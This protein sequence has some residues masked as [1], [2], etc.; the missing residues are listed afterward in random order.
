[1]SMSILNHTS[2]EDLT[3]SLR[4]M[5]PISKRELQDCIQ[6]LRN[7]LND[8]IADRNRSSV[9]KVLSNKIKKLNKL[10]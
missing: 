7:S 3:S 6:L 10:T 4:L 1:M 8:E 5:N 2:V 9:I